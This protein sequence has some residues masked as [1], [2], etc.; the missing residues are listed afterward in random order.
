MT[1]HFVF[2]LEQDDAEH[3]VRVF[4]TRAEA[5]AALMKFGK[6]FFAGVGEHLPDDSSGMVEALAEFNRYARI[7]AC[8]DSASTAL[9]PF[10][11][12]SKW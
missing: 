7:Y 1:T 4:A 9:T 11:S 5:E 2:Y 3:D 8:T 12:A 6:D 10:E